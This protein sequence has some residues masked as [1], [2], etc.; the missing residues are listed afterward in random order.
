MRSR[1][2][3]NGGANAPGDMATRRRAMIDQ[4]LIPRGIRDLR[5]L[6]AIGGVPR[7]A[8]VPAEERAHAYEDRALRIGHEQTISQPYTVAFMCEAAGLRNSDRVLEVGTGSGYGAAVL[9]KLAAEVYT[10]ERIEALY[11]AAAERLARLGYDNVFSFYT[12]DSLGLPEE[13]PF[14]A[15]LVTAAPDKIPQPLLGQLALG[16]RL[17]I[18]VGAAGEQR[19]LRVKR[20]LA[21]YSAKDLGSFSFVPLVLPPADA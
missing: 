17:V 16:G 5:V 14:Q 15:I 21:G 18:P 12:P 4:Q 13:G 20:G 19:I 7:E 8:F 11:Q 10:V 9:S 2:E 1:H 3:G 6:E